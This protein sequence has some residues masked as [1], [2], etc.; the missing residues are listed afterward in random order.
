MGARGA[1]YALAGLITACTATTGL[2]A[3]DTE[4]PL[5]EADVC[6]E[7]TADASLSELTL[8]YVLRIATADVVFLVDVTGSMGGE[9]AAIRE[10][11]RARLAPALFATSP[12][13]RRGVATFADF[14]VAPHGSPSDAPFV[15][16]QPPTD[17]LAAVENAVAALEASGGNDAPESQVEALF[18]LAS[19]AGAGGF[20]PPSRCPEGTVGGGCFRVEATPVVLLLTD[21][22][23]HNGPGGDFSYTAPEVR[24]LAARYEDARDALRAR[25]ARVLGL[26]S[27][28]R[29][30]FR[31]HVERI[32]ADSGAVGDDGAPLVVDIGSAGE[33]RDEAVAEVV[34]RL[35]AESPADID[36]VLSDVEGDDGDALALLR[37]VVAA[38]PRPAGGGRAVDGRYEDVRP[39]TR[40]AFTLR[41]D[42][43]AL[44]PR[45]VVQRFRLRVTIRG[46]GVVALERRTVDLVIPA[47]RGEGCPQ[48]G[49]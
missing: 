23:T 24:G 14:P 32:A 31:A 3:P 17:E 8:D 15:L 4:A 41:F 18:Q 12:G 46:D 21:A 19:G 48:P 49:D 30:E 2:E 33:G 35:V 9:V 28:T 47:E 38:P 6:L 20:I 16:G 37:D 1:G 25:G 27:G 7:L 34:G 43:D 26:F 10:G 39:G 44:A 22:G 36:L 42:V 11:L 45:A 29:P 13:T 40:V 5:E